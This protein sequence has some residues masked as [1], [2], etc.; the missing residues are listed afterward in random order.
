MQN[1]IE[2]QDGEKENIFCMM[3]IKDGNVYKNI[4]YVYT[5]MVI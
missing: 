3:G 4:Q 2:N 1:E 5:K